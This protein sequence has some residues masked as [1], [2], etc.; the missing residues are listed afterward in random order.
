[1]AVGEPLAGA[2]QMQ[3]WVLWLLA[4][5]KSYWTSAAS[6]ATLAG[7]L[8]NGALI[9]G[10]PNALISNSLNSNVLGQYNFFVRGG[11]VQPP[12]SVPEPGSLALVALALV[13]AGM[14]S[15]RK[16]GTAQA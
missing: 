3:K 2:V 14:V 10:G 13:A 7:S 8:V 5:G 6:N 11:V 16:I 4:R 1:L 15:R 12:I 9:N